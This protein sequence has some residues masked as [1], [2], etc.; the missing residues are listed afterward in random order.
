MRLPMASCEL[1]ED[2]GEMTFAAV[3]G[4]DPQY[5]RAALSAGPAPLP[6]EPL[7]HRQLAS[8]QDN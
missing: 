2:A 6:S 7:G 8:T 1:P 3:E 5:L 4:S